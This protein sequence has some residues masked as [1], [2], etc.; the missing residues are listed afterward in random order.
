MLNITTKTSDSVISGLCREVDYIR[1]RSNHL[2]QDILQSNNYRLISRLKNEHEYL[3]SRQKEINLLAR[4]WQNSYK[5]YKDEL[6]LEFLIE[7]S[8]RN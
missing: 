5:V 8:S 7:I 3:K 1:N 4:H 6:S 2:V